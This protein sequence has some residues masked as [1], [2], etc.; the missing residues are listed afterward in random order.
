M[1]HRKF[2]YLLL[3]ALCLAAASGYIG[4]LR[5][6]AVERMER[7]ALNLH[8]AAIPTPVEQK[9]IVLVLAGEPT[10]HELGSWPWSRKHHAQ[11]LGNLGLSRIVLLDILMPE[12]SAPDA[13]G[14]L[15]TVVK[16]MGNVVVACHLAT[17]PSGHEHLIYPYPAL[18]DAAARM[19][20]TNV[21]PD[22][23]GYLRSI[24]P[25]WEVNGQALASFPMAALSL[26][27]KTPPIPPPNRPWA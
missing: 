24:K 18:L 9:G 3:S 2:I 7:I 22:V 12:P 25:V 10:F 21:N 27:T 26:L 14:L 23:D 8:N 13:D 4:L 11:L 6:V 1:G 19:G 20:I 17:D 5:P 16:T 15:A